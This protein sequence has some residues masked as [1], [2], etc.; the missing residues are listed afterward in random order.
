[1]S[2]WAA[3][4]KAKKS[5][6]TRKVTSKSTS[7][8][9]ERTVILTSTDFCY[10]YCLYQGVTAADMIRCSLCMNWVHM[11]CSGEDSKYHGAWTCKHCRTIPS[12]ITT[13]QTQLS[14]LETHVKDVC[15]NNRDLNKEI[16]LLRTENG[17]LKQKVANLNEHNSELQKLIET[18]SE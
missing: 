3:A 17:N 15:K 7:K 11:A 18:M 4:M 10:S 8:L 1:M 5:K 16:S 9:T 6:K 13:L 2:N 14:N 12:V